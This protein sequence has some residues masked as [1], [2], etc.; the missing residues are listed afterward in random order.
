MGVNMF[1]HIDVSS[2]MLFHIFDVALSTLKSDSLQYKLLM[3]SLQVFNIMMD[4]NIMVDWDTV[5]NESLMVSV[6]S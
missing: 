5:W 1:L 4:S 2:N 3:L 6:V